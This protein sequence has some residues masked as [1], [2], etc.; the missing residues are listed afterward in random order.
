MSLLELLIAVAV[1]SSAVVLIFPAFFRA[2]DF[3]SRANVQIEAGL[4]ADNL[5]ARAERHLKEKG[6]WGGWP[7]KGTVSSGG[8]DFSYEMTA[9]PVLVFYRTK[10]VDMR[11]LFRLDVALAWA[12]GRRGDLTR[13]GYVL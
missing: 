4:A 13:T 7:M 3:F 6:H 10:L 8:T 9:S 5:L 1:F 12:S 2:G 11:R